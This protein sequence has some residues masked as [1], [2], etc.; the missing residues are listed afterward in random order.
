MRIVWD[1]QTLNT[2][3]CFN[4]GEAV[5]PSSAQYW[6]RHTG[7]WKTRYF[8]LGHVPQNLT[9]K[10]FILCKFLN[11]LMFRSFLDTRPQATAHAR[12]SP[13]VMLS[14]ESKQTSPHRPPGLVWTCKRTARQWI[15]ADRPRRIR[16]GK[17]S[18]VLKIT[19][20]AAAAYFKVHKD[21]NG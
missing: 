6:V 17:C 19:R 14:N 12:N 5:R 11:N 18:I 16:S 2:N 21:L 8:S 4:N 9:I 20:T 7:V 3:D 10:S 15:Q 1:P 13:R